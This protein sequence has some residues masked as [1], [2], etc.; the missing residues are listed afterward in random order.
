MVLQS[1]RVL[2]HFEIL[3]KL[4][5]CYCAIVILVDLNEKVSEL[6][7]VLFTHIVSHLKVNHLSQSWILP[8]F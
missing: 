4:I 7:K 8:F 5:R 2:I 1:Q 3:P 6:N